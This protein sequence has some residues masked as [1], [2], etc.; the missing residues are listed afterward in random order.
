MQV[1]PITPTLKAPGTK[2]LKLKNDELLFRLPFKLHLR[3]YSVENRA[4]QQSNKKRV[5]RKPGGGEPYYAVFD[6]NLIRRTKWSVPTQ[7]TAD[8]REGRVTRYPISI[9]RMTTSILSSPI[10]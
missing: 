8:A 7:R 5:A 9:R 3:R 6:A 4:Y 1:N 2:C 10:S